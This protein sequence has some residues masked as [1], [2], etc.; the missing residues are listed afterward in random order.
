[1]AALLTD[2]K[3]VWERN[4]SLLAGRACRVGSWYWSVTADP[5]GLSFKA[6]RQRTIDFLFR[7]AALP[8]G[9][10]QDVHTISRTGQG[11]TSQA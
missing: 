11:G 7:L 2:T 6:T 3:M 9:D 1:M 8:G 4:T 10:R 5:P